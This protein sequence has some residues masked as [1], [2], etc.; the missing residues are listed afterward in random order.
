MAQFALDFAT[1]SEQSQRYSGAALLARLLYR[2]VSDQAFAHA[3][4]LLD[5]FHDIGGVVQAAVDRP[6]GALQLSEAAVEELGLL[7]DL[8]IEIAREQVRDQDVLGSWSQ[9]MTYVRARFQSR[10]TECVYVL[11]LDRKNVFL[12]ERV[13]WE[14]TV[15]HAP[16][17]PRDLAKLCLDYEASALLVIHNHPSGDPKPSNAD[18]DMTK[19]LAAVLKSLEVVIHDH[20]IVGRHGTFSFK[21]NGLL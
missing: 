12:A 8:C 14:G 4:R 1:P 6:A 17:Y 11:L 2:H 5:Q 16:I 21:S 13:M 19:E 20:V 10:T 7:R 18:I 15:N 3:H 9:L